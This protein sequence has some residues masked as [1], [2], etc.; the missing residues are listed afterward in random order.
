MKTSVIDTRRFRPSLGRRSGEGW[1]Y[2]T[3]ASG[4]KAWKV[5][6]VAWCALYLSGREAGPVHP[7][8]LAAVSGED[9]RRDP[10]VRAVEKVMPAV[11]NIRTKTRVRSRGLFYDW[12][13][14]NW[15]PFTRDLPPEES[16]GSGV[17]IDEAGYVVTNV[18]V[19]EGADEIFVQI[20]EEIFQAENMVG[21]RKTDVA[22]LKLR[23]ASGRKFPAARFGADDDLLLGE[24][25]LAMGNPFGLG[26]SVS[27]G[28]LSSKSRRAGPNAEGE[29][30]EIAD[31]LQTDAA[32][33]PGN[34]GGPLVNLNGAMIGINVAVLKVGQGIGFAIPAKRVAE[35]LG[36]IFTPEVMKGLYYG[37]RVK[38]TGANPRIARVEPGSPAEKAGLREGD[39]I[40][41]VNEESVRSWFDFNRALVSTPE[42]KAAVLVVQRGE[43][44]KRIAV[45]GIPEREIFNE[46][47]IR[48][49]LG[50]GVKA[51]D[52]AQAGLP[53]RG[54]LLSTVERGG[55]AS[56]AGLSPQMILLEIEGFATHDV[57]ETARWLAGR[58]AGDRVSVIVGV[59]WRRGVVAGF[60]RQEGRLRLR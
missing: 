21:S 50:A 54:L 1:S 5:C 45:T 20:G 2:G 41:S 8:L 46:E 6:A 56:L 39:P 52:G 18:H 27:R 28:I 4:W 15:T 12:W 16:A 32:I 3:R 60:E 24:T 11:V 59:P 47:M 29:R 25:V 30:L 35:S 43:G 44:R 10:V 38:T 9:V 57:V 53:L 42:R 7:N 55:P 33:N 48:Q 58:K 26:G 19:V 13:R 49:R 31:W 17:V 34:S 22:L 40:L 51:W 14:E 37:L 23:V 36:E